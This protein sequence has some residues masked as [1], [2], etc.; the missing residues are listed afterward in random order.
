MKK[1]LIKFSDFSQPFLFILCLLLTLVIGSIRYLTG[2]EWEFSLFY[3]FP[4]CIATWFITRWAGVVLS[5]TSALSW[6]VAD[7]FLINRFSHYLVPCI[8]ELLRS[9]VFLAATFTLSELKNLIFRQEKLALTD[10]LTGIANRRA[11]FKYAE[12]ELMRAQ[13]FERPFT[14]AYMDIDNFKSINDKCGHNIGD[15]LLRS[16]GGTLKRAIRNVDIVARIG[17]D[18]F[19]LFL[20]ETDEKVACAIIRRIDKKLND[21]VHMHEWPISFSFGVVTFSNIPKNI[22]DIINKADQL[23]LEA[24]KMGKAK[25][26]HK[27]ITDVIGIEKNHK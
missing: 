24:K 2:T 9:I 1:I 27:I 7:M 6:F 22:D 13:R 15:V 11:F 23:L 25:I 26:R 18:E 10:T 20:P 4:I 19:V 3:L 5:I 14:I 12:I 17:G 8:N 16:I 21:F